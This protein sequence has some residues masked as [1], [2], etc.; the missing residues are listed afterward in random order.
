MVTIEVPFGG[1]RL[2]RKIDDAYEDRYAA[3][4]DLKSS[5]SWVAA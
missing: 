5:A 3:K 2:P 1:E 4:R